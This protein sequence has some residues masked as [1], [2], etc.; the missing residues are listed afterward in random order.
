MDAFTGKATVY[1][2][3]RPSYALA[4]LD[5]IFALL[6]CNCAKPDKIFADI[7][8]GTGKFTSLL[9]KRAEKAYAIEPNEDMR[10]QIKPYENIHVI[11]G[12]A[13]AT[14]LP[15]QSV[16]AITCAQ[17]FHWFDVPRFKQECERILKPGGR[18][19]VLYNSYVGNFKH[20]EL[21]WHSP[22]NQPNSFFTEREERL[23]HF[24]GSNMT[25]TTFPNDIYYDA[26]HWLAYMLSH[27]SSPRP[28]DADYDR[29]VESVQL[30][31][32]RYNQDGKLHRPLE[33]VVYT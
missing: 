11:D 9:A 29:F 3:A 5:Y 33:T 25:R 24:F 6:C 18:V 23:R 2:Q 28:G 19:F 10:T 20:D 30:I 12:T 8:A 4:A 17:A 15:K 14:T 13:E 16:D 1:A 22:E 21:I 7:G 31:F 32:A 26:E 27:S